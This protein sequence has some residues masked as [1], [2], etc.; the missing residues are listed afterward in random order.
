VRRH[1]VPHVLGRPRVAERA[2]SRSWACLIGQPV[3]RSLSPALHNA[4]F[5][6]AGVDACYD[7]REIAPADLAACIESM[8]AADCLGAN[9]TAPHKQAVLRL[10]DEV[11]DAARLLRAVNTI[12]NRGGWLLG[13]NTDARGLARWMRQVGID[14]RNGRALVLGA[15]GAAR[16]TVWALDALGAR[17]IVVLNRTLD[18][19]RA[20]VEDLAPHMAASLRSGALEDA[21]QPPPAACGVIVNATSLGHHGGGPVVHPDWYSPRSVAIELV[22]NPPVTPFSEAA[23]AAGART[24]NGLGMLVHQ[25]ALAFECWTGQPAP[26][27]VYEAAARASV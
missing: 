4:A 17:E 22:Y 7:A 26:L 3:S 6:A 18:R 13:D 2:V 10:V 23:Q 24:E 16:A 21:A 1:L 25:A 15:G 8:R 27:E 5:T 11:A 20:L 12:V 9:V 19:A 14:P